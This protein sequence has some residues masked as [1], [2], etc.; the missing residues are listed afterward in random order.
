[1]YDPSIGR[2]MEEDPIGFEAGDANLYR[3]VENDPA[4][5]IDPLGLQDTKPALF[6]NMETEK[7]Q[8]QDKEIADTEVG[9]KA[10]E[11]EV[12]E[13]K[14]RKDL[15]DNFKPGEPFKYVIVDGKFVAIKHNKDAKAPH[16][17]GTLKVQGK[18]GE[19]VEAAGVGVYNLGGKG[20]LVIDFDLRTGHYKIWL[21]KNWTKGRDQAQEGFK[22]VT[23][24]DGRADYKDKIEVP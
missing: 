1:M 16:S 18:V 9:K 7:R 20:E 23:G 3:Y 15:T 4:N 13:I 21:Q 24:S 2:W 17:F 6:P 19:P 12:F 22:K 10:L 14:T 8:K 5:E 11:K